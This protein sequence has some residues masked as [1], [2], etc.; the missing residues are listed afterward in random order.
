MF[1]EYVLKLDSPG[2][3]LLIEIL[4]LIHVFALLVYLVLLTKS[5]FEDNN[6]KV[7]QQ[8]KKIEGKSD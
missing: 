6:K 2:V 5:L 1:I 8:L 4:I 7:K 3:A